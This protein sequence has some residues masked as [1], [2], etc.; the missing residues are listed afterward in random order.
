[1]NN[2]DFFHT[3]YFSLVNTKSDDCIY[4]NDLLSLIKDSGMKEFIINKYN[5]D[6]NI[7][8]E[9]EKIDV[10]FEQIKLYTSH[11]ELIRLNVKENEAKTILEFNKENN[12]LDY[13]FLINEGIDDEGLIYENIKAAAIY[14]SLNLFYNNRS[15]SQYVKSLK[16]GERKKGLL[17]DLN[18]SWDNY[19]KNNPKDIKTKKFRLLKNKEQYYLKSI[20]TDFYKEYG[21]AESFVFTVLEIFK[22]KT[23]KPENKFI[24]SSIFLSESKIDLIITLDKKIQL[25][26]FGFI[27]PSISIR[28]EDQGNTSL[29]VYSTLEFISENSKNNK[30]Y[31][32]PKKDDEKIKYYKIANHTINKENLSI[33]FSS[34]SELFS[35]IDNFK[36]DFHFYKETNNYDELRHKIAERILT[37]NSVFKDVKELKELFSKDKTGH[38]ENLAALLSICEKAELINMDFDLKFKLRYLIS[39]VLLYNKNDF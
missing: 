10:I 8:I 28:N 36:N 33:L 17:E 31:L 32:Y 2:Y 11:F 24:I 27:K 37:G 35:H 23:K 3:K 29:G 34:I 26:R 21:I 20:N 12:S 18:N 22:I 7:K 39:N 1:M 15:L 5:L 19:F 16:K 30:I 6:S 4:S 25:E 14:D 13:Y 9:I 38:I